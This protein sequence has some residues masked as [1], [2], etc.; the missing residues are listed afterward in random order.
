[1]A[2]RAEI[3]DADDGVVIEVPEPRE[4]TDVGFLLF[5][6]CGWLFGEVVV[7]IRLLSGT[8]ADGEPMTW[9]AKLFLSGWLAFWTCG[10]ATAIYTVLKALFGRWIITINAKTLTS[11]FKILSF[12]R[13]RS[14]DTSRVRDFRL[15][16][17][18]KV[19][20]GAFRFDYGDETIS[21]VPHLNSAQAK[22]FGS[23]LACLPYLK[24][25]DKAV[26]TRA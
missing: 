24:L 10:G 3:R 15:S 21:I 12:E 17:E 11:T 22:A 7:S 1:M 6:L 23:R 4:G 25:E 20:A 9:S 13:T 5:W 8:E 19:E 14:W 2:A 18:S 16:P 26:P